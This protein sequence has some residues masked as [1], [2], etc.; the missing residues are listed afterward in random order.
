M[1]ALAQTRDLKVNDPSHLSGDMLVDREELRARLQKMT[2]KELRQFGRAALKMCSP[3]ANRGKPPREE[4][5]IQLEEARV[6]WKLRFQPSPK[7]RGRPNR[8]AFRTGTTVQR[9]RK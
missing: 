1:M 7:H 9:L 6:E 4:V 8:A 5:V 3:E 2:N